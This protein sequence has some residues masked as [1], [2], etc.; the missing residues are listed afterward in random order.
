MKSGYRIVALA[1]ALSLPPAALAEAPRDFSGDWVVAGADHKARD[2]TSSTPASAARHGGASGGHG[3]IGGEMGGGHG[4]HGGRHHSASAGDGSPRGG[5]DA[6]AG[7]PRSAAQSLAIRQSD[8]VFDVAADGGR[9]MVYRFDNRN[10][11]GPDY[12]GTVTLTWS[13]PDMIIETHPDGGGSV[14]ER[15]TLSGDAKQL[16]QH[17][18]EQR[19]GADSSRDFTRVFVRRGS[20]EAA[21]PLP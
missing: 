14:E 1:L 2:A 4:I 9:R 10:N 7:G 6:V 5:P 12:G 8:V 15:Y 16:T 19:A 20:S 18:H 21:S 13:A 17:V 11:Y 3:G